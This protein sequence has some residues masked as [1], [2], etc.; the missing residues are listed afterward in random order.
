MFIVDTFVV[1][2]FIAGTLATMAASHARKGW[3]SRET[4]PDVRTRAEIVR[5]APTPTTPHGTYLDALL[6]EEALHEWRVRLAVRN[7]FQRAPIGECVKR[8]RD[9]VNELAS[10]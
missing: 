7:T 5:S 9:I 8:H 3:W 4:P 10:L 1:I 6:V 2:L